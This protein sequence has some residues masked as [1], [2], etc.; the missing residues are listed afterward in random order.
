MDIDAA[1]G[2]TSPLPGNSTFDTSELAPRRAFRK[3]K[4]IFQERREFAELFTEKATTTRD[5]FDRVMVRSRGPGRLT[6]TS[7]DPAAEMRSDPF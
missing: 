7:R 5:R 4:T 6:L 2:W 3:K 1:A